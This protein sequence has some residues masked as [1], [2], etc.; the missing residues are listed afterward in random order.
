MIF[1]CDYTLWFVV[2]LRCCSFYAYFRCLLTFL[3]LSLCCPFK[4]S[5]W[6]NGRDVCQT[7]HSDLTISFLRCSKSALHWCS[8]SAICNY[9]EN[10]STFV[11]ISVR[12]E[13]KMLCAWKMVRLIS[14]TRMLPYCSITS[15]TSFIVASRIGKSNPSR[16]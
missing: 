10:R 13:S 4:R 6:T 12:F 11:S 15:R 5:S 9:Y 7:V 1:I 3:F 8:N 16:K 14:M 2:I